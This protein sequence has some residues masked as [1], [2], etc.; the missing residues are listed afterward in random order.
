MC[1]AT[2][3]RG[4]GWGCGSIEPCAVGKGGAASL[5]LIHLLPCVS[6]IPV[7]NRKGNPGFSAA[8]DPLLLCTQQ[9]RKGLVS[10]SWLQQHTGLPRWDPLHL[11]LG[12]P[13]LATATVLDPKPLQQP[14][15]SHLPLSSHISPGPLDVPPSCS[16]QSA[17]GLALQTNHTFLHHLIAVSNL[18]IV[19]N[20]GSRIL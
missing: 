9:G 12:A 3:P 6:P 18:Y 4:K 20:M 1:S 15:P 14:S 8:F 19:S 10:I 13:Q 17:Q 7:P 11:Q 16:A 5:W 2:S